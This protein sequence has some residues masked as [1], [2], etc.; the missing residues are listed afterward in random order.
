M[1]GRAD[2]YWGDILAGTIEQNVRASTFRYVEGF[3]SGAWRGGGIATTLSIEAG[4][5]EV[6]GHYQHAFFANLLPEGFRYERLKA[7][8]TGARDDAFSVLLAAGGDTIGSVT[9]VP[10]GERPRPPEPTVTTAQIAGTDVYAL[11]LQDEEIGVGLPGVQRK[12]SDHTLSF[13]DRVGNPGTITKLSGDDYPLQCANE[14]FFMSVAR[15]SG[16]EA[17]RTTLYHDVNGREVLVVER[18]DRGAGGKVPQEDGCQM[19]NTYA[20]GKYDVSWREIAETLLRVTD[21]STLGLARLMEVIAFSWLVGNA[22][23]HAKNVSIQWRPDVGVVLS[24]AY[25]LLSTLPYRHLDRHMALKMDGRD[26]NLKRK[27][28]LAFFGRHGLPER[29]IHRTLDKILDRVPRWL[30]RLEEI[31]YDGETT[32]GLR[33][34]IARRR[35][36]LARDPS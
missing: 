9:V 34:E 14:H 30:P 28:F 13:P 24:P 20:S 2:V 12:I 7:R 16:V 17:A 31:G 36:S 15:E 3:D 33:T 32:D 8:V 23:L 21:G 5:V 4:P 29:A 26:S 19:T 22:D 27:S 35:E 10:K 6:P 11:L 25:D 18:F 1:T